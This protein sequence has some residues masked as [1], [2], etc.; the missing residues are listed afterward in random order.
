MHL[1]NKINLLLNSI[2]T[3]IGS[4]FKRLQQKHKACVESSKNLT[5]V[6]NMTSLRLTNILTAF[7]HALNNDKKLEFIC[8]S[9][10][11]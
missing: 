11:L 7:F 3:S 8:K 9:E 2:L 5:K 6:A 4:T 10:I 1:V